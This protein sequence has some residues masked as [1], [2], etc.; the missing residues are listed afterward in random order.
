MSWKFKYIHNTYS[1]PKKFIL[2][3]R[4]C[5]A[6]EMLDMERKLHLHTE[7]DTVLATICQ[8]IDDAIRDY[9]Y[10][11]Y[12]HHEYFKGAS[13][14]ITEITVEVMDNLRHLKTRK[15]ECIKKQKL[16]RISE[17]RRKEIEG[18]EKGIGEEIAKIEKKRKNV[19][20]RSQQIS[21]TILKEIFRYFYIHYPDCNEED[22]EFINL[23]K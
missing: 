6:I 9:G 19:K 22:Q 5:S 4:I 12:I 17:K 11:I 16:E 7:Y 2:T 13:D 14:V 20:F 1:G 8:D 18:D 15:D 3:T 10:D 21:G 23:I